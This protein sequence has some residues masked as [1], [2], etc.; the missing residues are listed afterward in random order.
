MYD[1]ILCDLM[2]VGEHFDSNIGGASIIK[3][4]KMN[5]PSKFVVSYT[6]A[7]SNTVEAQSAK[8]Y[9][10]YFI[11]KDADLSEWS[12][13]LDECVDQSVDPYA[14]WLI[15]RNSLFDLELDIRDIV[16]LEDAYVKSVLG[17]DKQFNQL[18]KV[19]GNIS[20]EGAVKGIIQSLIASGIYGALFGV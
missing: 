15:A 9:A 20:A 12:D 18:T 3:E 4:I 2:G 14:M 11:K 7:R 13:I 17:S 8:E 10:D 5:F 1:I 19:L 6:G 16:K